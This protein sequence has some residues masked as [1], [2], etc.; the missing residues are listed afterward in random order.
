MD[1][2]LPIL[3]EPSYSLPGIFA[4][5]VYPNAINGSLW[6]LPVECAMYIVLPVIALTGQR[7]RWRIGAGGIV[8][9]LLSLYVVHARSVPLRIVVYGTDWGSALD[10]APYFFL[11]A[12]W[13]ITLPRWLLNPQAALL[14]MV[15]CC[16]I[17]TGQVIRETSLYLILP[18][19]VLSFAM[20]KPALFGWLGRYG[21]FSYGIYIYG[22]F[23]Q[24]I[25]SHFFRTDGRPLLNFAVSLL[26]TLLA[27]AVS[28]HFIEKPFLKLKPNRGR[29]DTELNIP[30]ASQLDTLA[31]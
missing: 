21:D 25:V 2:A 11:G 20:A 5:N 6:T 8:L 15:L 30:P 9:C 23:V 26:P 29:I 10:V 27:A 22:F 14:V 18:Y 1:L 3:L 12:L 13:Q 7:S 28:W 16:M 31:K 17:P 19:A 24:Q 4:T